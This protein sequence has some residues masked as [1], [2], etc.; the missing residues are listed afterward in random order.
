MKKVLY[1]IEV[2]ISHS[3]L[4]VGIWCKDNNYLK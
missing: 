3:N 2:N 1:V 4:F